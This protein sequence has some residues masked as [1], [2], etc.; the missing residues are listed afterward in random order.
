MNL[1][2]I[3]LVVVA[4]LGVGG[5]WYWRRRRSKPRMISLVALLREP[6]TLD[7]TVLAKTAGRAWNVDLGEGDGAGEDGFVFY[8]GVVNTICEGTRFYLVNCISMP[9]T[10]DPESAAESI[11]DLRLRKL[12]AQHRAWFSCDSLGADA[13][14]PE[15]E[16]REWYRR[17]GRLL[18]EF[19]DENC[20]LIFVPDTGRAYAI[21]ED[22]QRAL[23]SDDP[24]AALDETL[25]TPII[26]LPQDDALL[27]E[28]IAKARDGWPKFVAAFEAREGQGF[29]VKAPISHGETTEFIWL[30]VTAVEGELIYGTL[31]NEPGDLGP[32]EFGSKVSVPLADLN[33]WCYVDSDGTLHGGFTLSA[34]REAS[35][36]QRKA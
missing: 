27:Q 14:T 5:W 34:I 4:L 31:A 24:L 33:D 16:G 29:L 23:L 30:E 18:V 1:I 32:L 11:V 19:L 8:T 20:L 9:Y 13:S 22:T 17:L 25:T 26:W 3:A 10:D 6:M 7:G 2:I 21:N 15:E 12:F 36:Q 35:R 28:G